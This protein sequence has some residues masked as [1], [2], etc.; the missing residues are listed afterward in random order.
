M[1][2]EQSELMDRELSRKR[3]EH[4]LI[5]VPGEATAWSE[6]DPEVVAD[7]RRRI[8]VFLDRHLQG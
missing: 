6:S 3:V 1:P 5:T 4:E 8:L 2:Y 7:I